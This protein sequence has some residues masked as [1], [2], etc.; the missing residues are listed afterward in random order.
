M[1]TDDARRLSSA[2]QH[3]RRRQV[4]RTYK[5]KVNKSQIARDVGLS[6]SATCKIM[7][8]MKRGGMAAL[9]PRVRGRRP[10]DKRVLT[11]EQE[12]AI[13]RTIC[14]RRP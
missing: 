2:E 9:A 8:G 11:Q 13:Q 4:I 5:R 12:A 3:G 14:D 6:C 10:G 1:D 7:T